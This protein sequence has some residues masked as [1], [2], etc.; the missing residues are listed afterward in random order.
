MLYDS[1][2]ITLLK[3]DIVLFYEDVTAGGNWVKGRRDLPVLFH[4]RL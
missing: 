2:Y 3:C 1:I 4:K